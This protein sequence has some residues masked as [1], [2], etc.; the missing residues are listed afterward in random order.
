M[1]PTKWPAKIILDQCW[2]DDDRLKFTLENDGHIGSIPVSDLEEFIL[3][4]SARET[5]VKMTYHKYPKEWIPTLDF[6]TIQSQKGQY[7]LTKQIS[8]NGYCIV[9]NCPTEKDSVQ[10][11]ANC[12]TPVFPSFYGSTFD[13]VSVDN[14][15]NVAYTNV[16]FRD[17]DCESIQVVKHN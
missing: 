6:E 14:A 4:E 10:K 2:I 1:D 9:T 7:Q 17:F 12:I 15:I 8:T 13:V 16:E 5:S 3:K 11:V